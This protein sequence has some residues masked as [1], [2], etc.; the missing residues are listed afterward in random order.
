MSWRGTQA[1]R[2]ARL[3]LL[4]LLLVLS[5]PLLLTELGFFSGHDLVG[6]AIPDTIFLRQA[7][8][9]LVHGHVPYSQH[10]LAGPDRHLT[11]IYPPL[12][13]VLALP[14]LLAR[15]HYSA[16]FAIEMMVLLGGGLLTLRAGVRRAGITAPVVLF[17]AVLLAAV[18]PVALSRVDGL[19]GIALAGAALALVGR[20]IALALALVTLAALVKETVAVVAIPVV[21]WALWPPEGEPWAIG[22]R[23]RLAAVGRGLIPA[24]AVAVVFLAWSRGQLWGAALAG[25]HR[26]VEVESVPATLSYLVRPW[27]RLHSTIGSLAS[28]QVV[29]HQASVA[30]AVVGLVG[31]AGLVWGAVHFA[32]ERRRPA[33]S[34]AFAAAVALATTPVLSPQYL[35]DLM[36]VLALVALTEVPRRRANQLLGLAL[37]TAL[38]TQIEFPYLFSWVAAL[39]P[40][41]MALVGVRNLLLVGIAITLAWPL[42]RR[43]EAALGEAPTEA[44]VSLPSVLPQS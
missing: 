24:L 8:L 42:P 23:R 18:G 35:L 29:G 25:V 19:Q 40:L 15:T 27:L 1:L 41:A 31:V 4:P 39:N 10:F 21:V 30:A 38:L 5:I 16:G 28:V 34:I 14:A 3:L 20:R 26:G 6:A 17:A 2:I 9:G 12:S 36:P 13:L 33:T 22:F 32:R 7:A 44:G 11:F 37:V 43:E